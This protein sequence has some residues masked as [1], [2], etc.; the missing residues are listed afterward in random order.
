MQ[1]DSSWTVG[2]I[3]DMWGIYKEFIGGCPMS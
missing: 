2:D 3:L 1:N